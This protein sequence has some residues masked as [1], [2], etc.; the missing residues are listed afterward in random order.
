LNAFLFACAAIVVAATGAGLLAQLRRRGAADRMMGVQLAGT[1]A[2]AAILLIAA[3]TG[4]DAALD[5]ALTLGLLAAVAAAALV[6]LP[7]A[8]EDPEP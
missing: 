1:G 2:G 7:E 3:A 8:G 6:L 5:V 4:V